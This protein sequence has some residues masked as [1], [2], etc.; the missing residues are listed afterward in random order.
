LGGG[1]VG[2][3][4]FLLV[5]GFGL[6]LALLESVIEI[7]LGERL[8]REESETEGGRGG[9]KAAVVRVGCFFSAEPAALEKKYG[10]EERERG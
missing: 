5:F 3:A 2:I 10:D 9:V 8:Q 7:G 1:I 4:I 6:G